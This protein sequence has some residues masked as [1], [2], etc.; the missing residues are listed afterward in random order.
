MDDPDRQTA[1]WDAAAG[2][3]SFTHPLNTAW[4]EKHVARDARILDV[5]C[6]Q[7]RVCREL[8]RLGYTN[9]SGADISAA[10]LARARVAVPGA[11]FSLIRDGELPLADA[12]FDL[13]LLMAVLTCIPTDHGQRRLVDQIERVLAVGGLLFASVYLLQDDLRNRRRYDR[14]LPKH[15]VYG[16]FEIE[17]GAV[18]RHHDR[19]WLARLFD[20]F[21]VSE[22]AEIE[23]T[24]MNG[25]AARVAQMFLEKKDGTT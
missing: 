1:Y 9:V 17:D 20:R 24:T 13:V 22:Q 2:S 5:G 21:R 8:R 4:L 11:D 12:S 7:G 23:V 18:L 15:K 3:K 19:P 16:V 6:G 10:M 14:W 25:H